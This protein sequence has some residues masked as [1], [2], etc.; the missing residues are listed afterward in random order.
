MEDICHQQYSLNRKER[1][2]DTENHYGYLIILNLAKSPFVNMVLKQNLAETKVLT[3][4]LNLRLRPGRRLRPFVN[5]GP[6]V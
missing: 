1:S 3:L 6:E 5:T 2:H 4:R